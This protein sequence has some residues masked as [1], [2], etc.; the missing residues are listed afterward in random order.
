M[1]K[2]NSEPE[3]GQIASPSLALVLSQAGVCSMGSSK[4]R[5]PRGKVPVDQDS[6][7]LGKVSRDPETQPTGS[8][9]RLK[10][11][12]PACLDLGCQLE[13]QHRPSTPVV[14]E[15]GV[16]PVHLEFHGIIS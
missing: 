15:S 1:L 6:T 7:S 5:L 16:K 12:F 14:S 9:A 2:A 8:T 4:P 11:F 3:V 13:R 10:V